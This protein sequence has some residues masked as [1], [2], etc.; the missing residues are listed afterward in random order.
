MPR[1]TTLLLGR[2]ELASRIAQELGL[3]RAEVEETC[4]AMMLAGQLVGTP[5]QA[6]YVYGLAVR[7][8]PRVDWDVV[9]RVEASPDAVFQRGLTQRLQDWASPGLPAKTAR[10]ETTGARSNTVPD[11][12]PAPTSGPVVLP[13]A[14]VTLAVEEQ[15][16]ELLPARQRRRA[17]ET[18][19][20]AA[21]LG[22]SV[23]QVC[24]AL[25]RIP[26]AGGSR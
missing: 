14:R 17:G 9:A 22:L 21:L 4:R 7:A 25:A 16:R 18:A 12:A 3:P 23:R 13:R 10:A 2:R 1:I 20:V 5:V 6:T 19:R 8:E 24:R 11:P 15:L 26:V